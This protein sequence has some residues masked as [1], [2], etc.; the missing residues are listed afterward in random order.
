M[1]VNGVTLMFLR[2][3]RAVFGIAQGAQDQGL[4]VRGEELFQ[5]ELIDSKCGELYDGVAGIAGMVVITT[6]LLRQ[7]PVDVEIRFFRS[8]GSQKG[9]S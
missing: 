3:D 7:I 6:I 1:L 8:C 2:V 4:F 5:Q 9:R